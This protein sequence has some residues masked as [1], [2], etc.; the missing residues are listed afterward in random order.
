MAGEA[1]DLLATHNN[2]L[3]PS[4]F[5]FPALGALDAAHGPFVRPASICHDGF[6]HIVGLKAVSPL[7]LPDF[8][9][10]LAELEIAILARL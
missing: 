1:L 5:K 7:G 6:H 9:F 8:C 3:L 4:L 2:A 10:C